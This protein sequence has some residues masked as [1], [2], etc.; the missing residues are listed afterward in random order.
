MLVMLSA[1]QVTQNLRKV[2]SLS[3]GFFFFSQDDF[4]EE[5][6]TNLS[7][8]LA[9]LQLWNAQESVSV[10]IFFSLKHFIFMRFSFQSRVLNLWQDMLCSALNCRV[11]L[12]QFCSMTYNLA[13]VFEVNILYFQELDL[14][15]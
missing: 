1:S 15:D 8:V 9:A 2:E 12:Q 5:R 11:G 3:A 10:L 13:N 6:G 14:I 4:D 7:A